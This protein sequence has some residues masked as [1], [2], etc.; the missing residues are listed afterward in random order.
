MQFPQ[1]ILVQPAEIPFKT[2]F[3]YMSVMKNQFKKCKISISA[4]KIPPEN[5]KTQFENAKTQKNAQVL[6]QVFLDRRSKKK[7]PELVSSKS[8][9]ISSS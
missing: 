1:S 2:T 7:S 5:P 6:A 9:P 4:N 3:L 8:L